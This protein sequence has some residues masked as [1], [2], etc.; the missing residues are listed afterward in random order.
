[1]ALPTVTGV[2]P[3]GGPA[4]GG[5]KVTLT[6]TNFTN[7]ASVAFGTGASFATQPK[8]VL[9]NSYATEALLEEAVKGEVSGKVVGEGAPVYGFYVASSTSIVCY[10]PPALYEQGSRYISGG[11]NVIVTNKSGESSAAAEA[12]EYAYWPGSTVTHFGSKIVQTVPIGIK[13]LTSVYP[14]S[15][16]ELAESAEAN[17]ILSSEFNNADYIGAEI[18]V[19]KVS[20]SGKV[21][22]KVEFSEDGLTWAVLPGEVTIASGGVSAQTAPVSQV[23]KASGPYYR[24]KVKNTYAGVTKLSGQITIVGDAAST[25]DA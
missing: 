1:M 18:H 13:A 6:G 21:E 23:N 22:V 25:Y 7:V 14:E 12:N 5:T 20:A 11:V 17:Y 16:L 2:S 3:A 9:T 8:I 24:V 4:T 10:A 15:F 19:D